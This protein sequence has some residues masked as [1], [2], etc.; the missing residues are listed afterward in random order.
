MKYLLDTGVWLW[1]VGETER[2]NPKARQVIAEGRDEIYL[3]AASVWEI[4]IKS[5]LRK[6][7]LPER[8]AIYVP[9]RIAAQGI[10]PLPITHVHALGVSDLPPH[11]RDPFDRILIAQAQAE[12]MTILTADRAFVKYQVEVFWCG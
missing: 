11:H 3:S 10:Q 8:P 7:R 5:A 1:S 2:I 4:S 12:G 9:S 6:M